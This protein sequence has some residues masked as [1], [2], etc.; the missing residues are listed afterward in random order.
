MI[1]I[2]LNMPGMSGIETIGALREKQV[3]ARFIMLTVS[4]NDRDVVSAL[5]AERMAICSR[6]WSRR[7]CVIACAGPRMGPRC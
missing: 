4:D 1:L 3:D 2:D 5:R 7:I 6:I